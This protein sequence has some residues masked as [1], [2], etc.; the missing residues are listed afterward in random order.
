MQWCSHQLLKHDQM[1]SRGEALKVVIFAGGLGSRISEESHLRPKPMIEIG[2]KPILWH[3]M[4]YYYSFGFDEFVIC[5]GYK[6]QVIKEYFADYYLHS[7]DVTF[8]YRNGEET[9]SVHGTKAEPWSV[10][11]ADTGVDTQTAGRLRRIRKYVQDEPFML[12]YGDGLSD[13]NLNTLL[14]FHKNTG[15]IVTLTGVNVAQRFGV[16]DIDDSGTVSAFR[17][18]SESD[19]SAVNGGF[20]VVEPSIFNEPLL[21]TEDFSKN[22]LETLASRNQLSAY[23][24]TGFWQPMD[25]QR[26]KFLLEDIWESH[27]A[28]WKRW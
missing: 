14:D 18:K 6:Q 11:V 8:D 10:T 19:V 4:K 20:M 2:N 3:I 9:I 24:H 7:S 27:N 17:E 26:D 16:L 23:R 28:P 1:C 15:K 21:D 12:T 22:T 5:A 13:V 25:T